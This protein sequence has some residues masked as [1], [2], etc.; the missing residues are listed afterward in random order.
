[1]TASRLMSVTADPG[2]LPEGKGQLATAALALLRAAEPGTDHQLAWMQLLSWTAVTPEQL[3]FVTGL[4]DGSVT[5]PG[6]TV[7]TEL[8]WAFLRRL[9]A[10]GRAG[11]AQIEAELKRDA[12]DAGRRHA[13]ACRA[14]IPEAGHKAEAWRLMA[15]SGS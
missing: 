8:R 15:E 4:L 14:A 7:D 5:V 9:A 10:L 12:T 1:M 3:D 6:L 11:D 13:A 2:W